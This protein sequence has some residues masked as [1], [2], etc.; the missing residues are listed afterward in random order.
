VWAQADALDAIAESNE[1]NNAAQP[2][3]I[4]AIGGEQSKCGVI[5]ADETWY[6]YVVYKVTCDVIVPGGVALTVQPRAEARF[7]SGKALIV[8]GTLAALGT[9]AQPVIFTANTGTPTRGFWRGI[10]VSGHGHANLAYATVSYG[11]STSGVSPYSANLYVYNNAAAALD[12]VTVAESSGHGIRL[13]QDQ[14]AVTTCLTVTDSTVGSS[15]QNGIYAHYFV[16]GGTSHIAISGTT[17]ISNANYAIRLVPKSFSFLGGGNTGWGNG[18]N[19]LAMGGTLLQNTV[20][21]MNTVGF[22]YILLAN[23]EE[24]K[25]PSGVNL[26]VPAGSVI[27]MESGAR[28]ALG[29][30]LNV[31]GT[32]GAPVYFTSVK[33]DS[34]WG[35][36]NGD[37]ATTPSKGDWLGVS[38]DNGGQANLAFVILRYGGTVSGTQTERSSLYL[39]K[40]VS[41]TL[42]HVTIVDSAGHGVHIYQDDNADAAYLTVQEGNI[43]TSGQTGIY[44]DYGMGN[45]T[46]YAAISGTR[47]LSNTTYAVYLKPRQLVFSGG[48]NQ[49]VG[50]GKNGIAL[51]GKLV[52]NTVLEANTGFPYIILPD[53]ELKVGAGVTLTLPASCIIKSEGKPL[54]VDGTLVAQGTPGK[55]I[56]F[57]SIKDDA[58]GGDTDGASSVPTLK[59][60]QGIYINNSRVRLAYATVRYAGKDFGLPPKNAGL[61]ATGSSHTV[62]IS[63]SNIYSNAGYG[64]YN[65]TAVSVTATHNWWGSANGPCPPAQ[66]NCAGYGDKVSTKVDYV[67]WLTSIVPPGMRY[68]SVMRPDRF[69]RRQDR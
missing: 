17:F 24:L 14:N 30:V 32:E 60:W 69:D 12:H 23:I 38:V 35:D 29:G 66:S 62:S 34:V 10:K 61:Y 5:S 39:R 7:D 3:T 36:T 28:L 4:T 63:N 37:G 59:D 52:Q 20:L 55:L 9:P 53:V 25:A 54:Y 19:G 47:F 56:Y 27:K 31:N 50:N 49:G 68:A 64:I 2:V 44:S 51:G 67:P 13:Y 57:T 58:V 1:A 22:P 8:S 11:G 26:T 45:G 40:N 65:A 42:D 43:G 6:S 46:V 18:K 33:D 15:N 41:A 48:N 16:N 21:A